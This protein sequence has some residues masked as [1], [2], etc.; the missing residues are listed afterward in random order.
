MKICSS[1]W[2]FT[3]TWYARV[4]VLWHCYASNS[5][6]ATPVWIND[7]PVR[8][9]GP[10]RLSI[11]LVRAVWNLFTNILTELQERNNR[12]TASLIGDCVCARA[13]THTRTHMH[14]ARTTHLPKKKGRYGRHSPTFSFTISSI[15]PDLQ[16][17]KD[18]CWGRTESIINVSFSTKA[19]S[20]FGDQ[21]IGFV[22]SWPSITLQWNIALEFLGRVASR[23]VTSRK[24]GCVLGI[25]GIMS[26]KKLSS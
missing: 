25:S 13:H 26:G 2:K 17:N 20:N 1:A 19:P 11:E 24:A 14:V 22:L 12:K 6:A 3:S 7:E 23:G 16:K 8:V 10:V 5:H 21:T 18:S 15:F 9:D 4:Y